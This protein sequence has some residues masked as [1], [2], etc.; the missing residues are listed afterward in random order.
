MAAHMRAKAKGRWVESAYA[1]MTQSNRQAGM[2]DIL[3]MHP[4]SASSLCI[5]LVHPL[6]V[7]SQ[8]NTL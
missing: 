8:F 4:F 5:L 7:S 1:S 6:Y 2:T 3:S